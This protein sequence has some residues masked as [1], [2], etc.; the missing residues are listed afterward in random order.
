MSTVWMD[1][2]LAGVNSGHMGARRIAIRQRR[3]RISEPGA[4]CG[5]QLGSVYTYRHERERERA[6]AALRCMQLMFSIRSIS[7]TVKLG[8]TMH[9]LSMHT[10]LSLGWST[11]ATSAPCRVGLPR[12]HVTLLPVDGVHVPTH[13]Q[14]KLYTRARRTSLVHSQLSAFPVSK[15]SYGNT[16]AC[17]HEKKSAGS[18]LTSHY[19]ALA[20][21]YIYIYIY[22]NKSMASWAQHVCTPC[23]RFRRLAT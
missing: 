10:T 8:L 19:P 7:G 14:G 5:Q 13:E 12:M 11:T 21:E 18:A 16:F 15:I 2:G 4:A 1:G 9:L 6:A 17:C 23:L 20:K 22:I 3:A